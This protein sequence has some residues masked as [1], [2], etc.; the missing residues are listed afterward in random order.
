M[1]TGNL[2]EYVRTRLW[3]APLAGVVCALVAAIAS[4]YLDAAYHAPLLASVITND[5]ESA[6]AVLTVVASAMIAL[7]VF[8]FSMTMLVI[9]LA[10]IQY[11]P[12]ILRTILRDRSTKAVLTLFLV[13]FVY[14]IV[15]LRGIDDEAEAAIPEITL[16][17]VYLLSWSALLGFVIF[18]DHVAQSLRVGRLIARLGDEGMRILDEMREDAT[19]RRP[20]PCPDL[21]PAGPDD[22]LLCCGDEGGVISYLDEEDLVAEAA[23]ADILVEV[24]H[25]VGDF[26][27]RGSPLLRIHGGPLDDR[28]ARRLVDMVTTAR[29][30]TLQ[31]DLAFPIRQLVDIAIRALSPGVNDPTTAVQVIDQLHDLLRQIALSPE[32]PVALADEDG[33]ARLVRPQAGWSDLLTLAITEIRLSGARAPQVTRRLRAMLLDLRGLKMASARRLAVDAQIH[34][35]DQTLAQGEEIPGDRR[36]AAEPDDQGI[37]APHHH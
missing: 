27:P 26:V 32:P 29:E 3:M 13:T 24:L 36:F 21:P 4:L 30:R 37:G 5:A 28:R 34:L 10:S 7:T 20:C 2:V 33:V 14:S 22:L 17:M 23:R 16:A 25:P 18:V 12:R 9:Q 15:A 19:R 31:Q 35:L 6:R 11:S 1:A 8:T